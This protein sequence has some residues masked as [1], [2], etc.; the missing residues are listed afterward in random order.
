V[1][2]GMALGGM[3]LV[4]L[5]VF[6]GAALI[7]LARQSGLNWFASLFVLLLAEGKWYPLFAFLFGW[8]IARRQCSSGERN[9]AFFWQNLRRMAVLALFGLLHATLL[10]EGDILF[11]YA[12]MGMLLPL[13]RHAPVRLLVGTSIFTLLLSALLEMPGPGQSLHLVYSGWLSSLLNAHLGAPSYLGALPIIPRHVTLYLWKLAY[14]PDWLGNFAALILLGYLAGQSRLL[15][16]AK[17]KSVLPQRAVLL[18]AVLLNL[19]YIL[20]TVEPRM[21]PVEWVG[22]L[23]TAALSLGGPLLALAYVL[24]ILLWYPSGR[25]Q[26][27]L[28]PLR[29]VGR[30]PL[31]TYLCQSLISVLLFSSTKPGSFTPALVWPLAGGIFFIQILFARWWLN[32][33]KR[34]PLEA[35]WH[36]MSPAGGQS[37]NETKSPAMPG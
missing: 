2:R 1:V 34:G 5:G 6:S 20:S 36:W 23:R 18:L 16:D 27:L 26:T 25:S 22:F 29:Q 31:T 28:E 19:F 10:W 15:E 37:L 24:A 32:R 3:L 21:L 14:F 4:N 12:L 17:L 9:R 33:F 30:M 35:V 11:A 7:P 8:G 13:L